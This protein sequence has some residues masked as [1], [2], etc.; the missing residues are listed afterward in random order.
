[1]KLHNTISQHNFTTQLSFSTKFY[2]TIIIDSGPGNGTKKMYYKSG[3]RTETIYDYY[4]VMKPMF[5][6]VKLSSQLTIGYANLTILL[7]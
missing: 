3:F 7:P 4:I 6:V 1:M 2:N 5:F